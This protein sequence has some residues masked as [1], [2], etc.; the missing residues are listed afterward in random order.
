MKAILTSDQLLDL[1]D[2]S[3]GVLIHN[4]LAYDYDQ[5][6]PKGTTLSGQGSTPLGTVLLSITPTGDWEV[7]PNDPKI[8]GA[9][10]RFYK[11]NGNLIVVRPSDYDQTVPPVAYA[12]VYAEK[13]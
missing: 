1:K 8:V 6:P 5:G 7:R 10:E 12:L 2:G 4:P 9:W 13:K 11:Q 3:F